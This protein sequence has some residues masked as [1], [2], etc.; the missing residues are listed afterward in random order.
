M[1][2]RTTELFLFVILR[3]VRRKIELIG[4]F[5]NSKL[6]F[7]VFCSNFYFYKNMLITTKV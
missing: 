5:L 3:N 4:L 6:N 1:N 7:V 2:T